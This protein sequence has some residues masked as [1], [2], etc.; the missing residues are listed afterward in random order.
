MCASSQRYWVAQLG[1]EL[2]QLGCKN[3]ILHHYTPNMCQEL[4]TQKQRR[5]DL[6]PQGSQ[7]LGENRHSCIYRTRWLQNPLP[8]FQFSPTL[9]QSLSSTPNPS[10]LTNILTA[11]SSVYDLV[12]AIWTEQYASAPWRGWMTDL[13][14]F[15]PPGFTPA[16][17]SSCCRT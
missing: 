4:R 1:L 2:R 9:S 6:C 13:L 7:I 3:S 11:C 10:L 15:W 14:T 5:W 12:P 17:G 8:C 16:T